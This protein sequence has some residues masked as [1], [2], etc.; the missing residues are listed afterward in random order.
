MGRNADFKIYQTAVGD[1][2]YRLALEEAGA[3]IEYLI[4]RG[5]IQIENDSEVQAAPEPIPI[6][7]RTTP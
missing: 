6:Y 4:L 1:R 3:H 2:I 5:L 7:Y